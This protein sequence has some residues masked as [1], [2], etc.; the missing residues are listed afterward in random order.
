MLQDF[1]TLA[2][3]DTMQA[4]VNQ[5]F[6]EM[7]EAIHEEISRSMEKHLMAG[8]ASIDDCCA[9]FCNELR[10]TVKKEVEKIEQEMMKSK[11]LKH[12]VNKYPSVIN[13]YKRE[14]QNKAHLYIVDKE[15]MFFDQVNETRLIKVEN[16]ITR[17]LNRLVIELQRG[18]TPDENSN[19]NEQSIVP[20]RQHM[21]QRFDEIFEKMISKYGQESDIKSRKSY[22]GL[23]KR[24]DDAYQSQVLK[25]NQVR[26]NIPSSLDHL[27][28][29]MDL[30]QQLDKENKEKQNDEHKQELQLVQDIQTKI[31]T[32]CRNLAKERIT[33]KTKHNC[34]LWC[35]LFSEICL[36]FQDLID[37]N[38][39]VIGEKIRDSI[40]CA[41]HY[42]LR[43]EILN[44]L[45]ILHNSDVG[46]MQAK[47]NAMKQKEWKDFERRVRN[48]ETANNIA[49][50]VSCW[51]EKEIS[52]KLR[53][54]IQSVISWFVAN[55]ENRKTS[56]EYMNI[57]F[58][59]AFG[60]SDCSRAF[61]LITNPL[62]M[63]D[64]CICAHFDNLQQ[65]V[66]D[67]SLPITKNAPVAEYFRK[68][69]HDIIDSWIEACRDFKSQKEAMVKT[70]VHG[71]EPHQLSEF[72][73][74]IASSPI[75][76]KRTWKNYIINDWTAFSN[77]LRQRLFVLRNKI[78]CKTS[79]K[80]NEIDCK[81]NENKD[82]NEEKMPKEANFL[83][84]IIVK[85]FDKCEINRW[86][87]CMGC[88][89]RCPKCKSKCQ[90]EYMHAGKH[91]TD[92]HY[93]Q[94]FAGVRDANTCRL[95]I[96]VCNSNSNSNSLWY[97]DNIGTKILL[98]IGMDNNQ[99][100]RW[101][102][103][104]MI[105]AKHK[106]WYPITKSNFDKEKVYMMLEMF[107]RKGLQKK[108]IKYFC[109]RDKTTS[110]Y[111]M[112]NENDDGCQ[113]EAEWPDDY[114]S[115]IEN[116]IGSGVGCKT[117]TNNNS[118]ANNKSKVPKR[119]FDIEDI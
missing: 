68:I 73:A 88:M 41:T 29:F 60:D 21:H 57:A 36:F 31:E 5:Y 3:H 42:Q 23:E 61:E 111:K 117:E 24:F 114:D 90:R 95:N 37:S 27:K 13:T 44:Q 64:E 113:N 33:D 49:R 12:I 39:D 65:V 25:Y 16:D 11:S 62:N 83:A 93:L 9:Q 119:N 26:G 87:Y 72:R 84:D 19:D 78:Y 108:L 48:I 80:G 81:E 1:H 34:N 55:K 106:D 110:K 53:Y 18:T 28:S 70:N 74:G 104:E 59:E 105:K 79:E 22:Q 35:Q 43:F 32:K 52:D 58:E 63:I 47:I 38:N 7:Q 86:A 10:E 101:T 54:E 89:E 6:D 85:E 112:A 51:L 102:W 66:L 46:K 99:F 107:F 109:D 82:E 100:V 56:K 116:S 30:C 67:C 2:A 40:M 15:G 118:K 76:L 115:D 71:Q 4:A 45:V 8:G 91:C 103:D 92:V 94:A 77:T 75:V 20:N 97:C 14:L 50:N 98:K 69:A 17:Q 96:D